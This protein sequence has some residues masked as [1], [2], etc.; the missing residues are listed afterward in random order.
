[1]CRGDGCQSAEIPLHMTTSPV[2]AGAN[3]S[4]R[5]SANPA[6][7]AKRVRKAV[8]PAA[9]L[10]TRFLPA[11]KA[12]PKEMIAVMSVIL[13]LACGNFINLSI[14][15]SVSR[16]LEVAIRKAT[17]AGRAAL[18]AQ[19]LGESVLQV[20]LALVLA[21]AFVEWCL[22]AVNNFLG[23][24]STFDYWHDPLLLL[25]MIAG[26]V[27]IGAIAGLYPAFVLSGFRPATV[28]KGLLRG[29]G[30]GRVRQAMVGFQ[31]AAMTVFLIAA[32]VA[33]QQNNFTTTQ[34]RRVPTAQTLLIRMPKCSESL[35]DSLKR[36]AN[37][38]GAACSSLSLLPEWSSAEAARPTDGGQAVDLSVAPV[39]Y[40]FMELYGLKP[41]AGR[42][43][44]PAAG[45]TIDETASNQ[46]IHY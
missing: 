19:F 11:T 29:G 34:A 41:L 28:L 14:A 27:I 32:A 42:F 40:G 16:G 36:L 46:D 1:Y 30:P 20:L 35:R 18:I 3:L 38:Q 45:D 26:A 23:S 33:L 2:A 17:G 39:G 7:A 5:S 43:F 6:G 25:G 10:G 9:G 24:G 21:T 44:Q 22:P 13:L 37:V 31:F 4:G 8:L 12:Q 15:R